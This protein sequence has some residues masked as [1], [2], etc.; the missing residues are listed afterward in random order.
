MGSA[1]AALEGGAFVPNTPLNQDEVKDEI[2]HIESKLNI[3]PLLGSWSHITKKIT[4]VKGG[5]DYWYLIEVRPSEGKVHI[6]SFS[7]EQ[8]DVANKRYQEIELVNK[9]SSNNAVLVSVNSLKN[10][11]KTYPNY[12]ADTQV[13]L[14]SLA[15]FVGRRGK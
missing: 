13:F 4:G 11:Q 5:K 10:L 3:A 14:E 2:I 7:A 8:R 6:A 1:H 15:T 9:G 12:F